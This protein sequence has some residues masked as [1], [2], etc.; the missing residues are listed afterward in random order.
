VI[1]T[2]T[3]A[4]S[5]ESAIL[6]AQCLEGRFP[7]DG[8]QEDLVK[9]SHQGGGVAGVKQIAGWS[10]SCRVGSASNSGSGMGGDT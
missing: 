5:G 4:K 9:F 6:R 1:L 7:L 3:Q 2:G 8:I 10:S